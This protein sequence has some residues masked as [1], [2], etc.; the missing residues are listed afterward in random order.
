MSLKRRIA[1]TVTAQVKMVMNAKGV[2]EVGKF[3]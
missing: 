2:V 3:L 1:L